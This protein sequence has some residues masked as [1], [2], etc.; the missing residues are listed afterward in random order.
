MTADVRIGP[1]DWDSAIADTGGPQ[2]VVAGPGTGKTEFLV[3][4]A[5]RLITS[6]QAD[7][8]EI[9]L[10]SFSRRDNMLNE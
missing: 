2:I 9:L 8:G 7:P 5:I 3:R 1:D 4:R 6:R 10:L